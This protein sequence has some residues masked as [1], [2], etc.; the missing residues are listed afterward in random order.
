MR[1]YPLEEIRDKK[2]LV[3]GDLMLDRYWFGEVNRISP[4]APVPVVRVV[5][6]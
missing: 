3:A 2:I 1:P 5:N 6:K 4:E